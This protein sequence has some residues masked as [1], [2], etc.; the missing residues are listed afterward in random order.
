MVFSI[1]VQNRVSRRRTT[2]ISLEPGR[3][4]IVLTTLHPRSTQTSGRSTTHNVIRVRAKALGMSTMHLSFSFQ[5][6]RGSDVDALL[7]HRSASSFLLKS[8]LLQGC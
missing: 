6:L 8:L 7:L 5:V 1:H 2:H 3:S 4:N